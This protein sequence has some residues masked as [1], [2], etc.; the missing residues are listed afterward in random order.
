MK[1]GGGVREKICQGGVKKGDVCGRGISFAWG[2]ALKDILHSKY[3]CVV[4]DVIERQMFFV[5][6]PPFF[7]Y[8]SPLCD[9]FLR[10]V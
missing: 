6:T 7:S 8:F 1:G 9:V 5:F 4:C 2:V 3:F 10:R